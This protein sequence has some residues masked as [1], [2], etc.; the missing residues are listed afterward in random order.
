MPE[1]MTSC[2][3]CGT[4]IPHGQS[5]CSRHRSKSSSSWAHYAAKYPQQAAYY[6][7]QHWRDCRASQLREHPDCIVCGAKANH[8]DHITPLAEGG[9]LDGPLQ[10]MCVEHHRR[11]TQDESKQGNERA[12]ARRRQGR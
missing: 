8:I 5:R 1:I 2:I 10:S 12:A 9:S 6:H 7:S 11:K 4:P 3:T